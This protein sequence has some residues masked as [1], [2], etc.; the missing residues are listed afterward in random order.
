M[1]GRDEIHPVRILVGNVD[2]D[3]ED[4]LITSDGHVINLRTL[5]IEWSTEPFGEQ[6]G[7]INSWE[8][9]RRREIW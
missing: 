1:R 2:G 6:L 7:A 8:M 9:L 5:Y 3:P 4:E